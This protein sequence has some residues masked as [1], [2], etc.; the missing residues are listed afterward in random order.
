MTQ[1]DRT[2]SVIVTFRTRATLATWHGSRTFWKIKLCIFGNKLITLI[3]GVRH[4]TLIKLERQTIAATWSK[5]LI[6]LADGTDLPAYFAMQWEWSFWIWSQKAPVQS[7]WSKMTDSSFSLTGKC[8]LRS[9][10]VHDDY[11]VEEHKI[12]LENSRTHRVFLN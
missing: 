10:H 6:I 5:S 12:Y 2:H 11:M 7:L 9:L 1:H 4:K 8:W 3:C